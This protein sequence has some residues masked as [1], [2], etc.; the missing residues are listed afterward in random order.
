MVVG[1]VKLFLFV[2]GLFGYFLCI[3]VCIGVFL[4]LYLFEIVEYLFK[5]LSVVVIY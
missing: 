4:I 5:Y 2:F 1:F 3:G